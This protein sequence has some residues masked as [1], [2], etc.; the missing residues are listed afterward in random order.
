MPT[1]PEHFGFLRFGVLTA[2]RGWAT[3]EAVTSAAGGWGWGET[4]ASPNGVCG[5]IA[6]LPIALGWKD[7]VG[8][9]S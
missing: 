6:L 9:E 3:A 2:R 5:A 4:R 1:R 7:E 8:A